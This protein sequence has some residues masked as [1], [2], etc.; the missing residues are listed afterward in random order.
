MTDRFRAGS[1]VS[2]IGPI[3]LDGVY[4]NSAPTELGILAMKGVWLDAHRFLID[5]QYVGVG[6]QR[7]WMLSLYGERLTLHGRAR[8]GREVAIE[9]EAPASH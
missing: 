7:Q 4:R 9:S 6:E 3:G 5:A 1:S 2:F 8:D